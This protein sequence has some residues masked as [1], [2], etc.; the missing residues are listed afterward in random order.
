MEYSFSGMMI[1]GE[2]VGS[3]TRMGNRTFHRVSKVTVRKETNKRGTLE[4]KVLWF[5]SRDEEAS[6]IVMYDACQLCIFVESL[7]LT[8]SS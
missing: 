5:P 1:E 8:R 6:Y 4:R 2:I 7:A 3:Y